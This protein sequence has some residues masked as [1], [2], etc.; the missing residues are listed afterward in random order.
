MASWRDFLNQRIR[1]ASKATYYQDRNVRLVLVLV[2]LLNAGL[3]LLP[4]LA[5]LYPVALLYWLEL[6][7]VKT[8]FEFPFMLSVARFYR[9]QRLMRWFGFLQPV[10]IAYTVVAGW[11]GKFGTYRWKGRRV[12]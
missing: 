9:L 5:F 8:L 1:W 11:L 2:Y 7:V 10:H 6:L 12:K 3:F 4:L